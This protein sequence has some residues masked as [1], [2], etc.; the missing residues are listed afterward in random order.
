MHDQ[1]GK[2]GHTLSGF[3]PSL[4]L[5]SFACL[6]SSSSAVSFFSPP[7]PEPSFFFFSLLD[8]DDFSLSDFEEDDF[9]DRL[10]FSLSLSLSF[11][12]ECLGE[13]L[14]ERL[15]LRLW[16]ECRCE[17]WRR[18]ERERDRERLLCRCRSLS[19]SLGDLLRL[20]LCERKQRYIHVV[21]AVTVNTNQRILS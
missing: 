18:G 6:I 19:R 1:Y 5:S 7:S 13:W 8:F 4:A 17:S 14:R 3:S 15:L 2:N 20:R 9:S 10:L 11:P 21:R 12:D 16:C